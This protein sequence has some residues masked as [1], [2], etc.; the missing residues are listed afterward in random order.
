M[1]NIINAIALAAGLALSPVAGFAA[2]TVLTI[3]SWAPPTHGINAKLWPEFTRMLEEATEGR[4]SA[5]VKFGLGSPPAQFDLVLD[6]AADVTWIFHGYNPG[7]FVATKMIELPG[8]EGNAEAASAAYWSA[9]ET[10]LAAANEHEG[11]KVLAMMTHGPGVLHS[12]SE[13]TSLDQIEG[14]KLRL[15][16]GVSGDVGTALGAT[17]IRVPAPKV[18][19][20]LASRAADGVMM[21]MEA[22]AG[23]KLFEVAPHSYVVPGGFYRGSFAIVMNQETYDGL[24]EADRAALDA[25]AGATLSRVAGKVWDEID[26]IGLATVAANDGNTLTEA[27]A[28]DA[29]KWQ[30]L[31]GPLIEGVLAEV[32]A[33]GIDAPAVQAF[34]AKEMAG[35]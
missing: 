35:N 9:Y 22:R 12:E 23:F 7:R 17:G 26:G 20:T 16:G 31:T 5:E 15:G 14:M 13:V 10:F 18:Y 2:D 21:P 32:S 6:G 19:E 24:A 8:Y 1:K 4:V 3:S 34:I 28:Q 30:E 27:S 29:A 25:I 33:K 11:V